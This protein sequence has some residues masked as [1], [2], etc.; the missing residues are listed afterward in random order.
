MK[1]FTSYG[2]IAFLNG[3]WNN[4][5]QLNEIQLQTEALKK[6]KRHWKEY[7]LVWDLWNLNASLRHK[8]KFSDLVKK[9]DDLFPPV[10]DLN[11][12]YKNLSCSKKVMQ[13]T[14]FRIPSSTKYVHLTFSFLSSIEGCAVTPRYWTYFLSKALSPRSK[15]VCVLHID[16]L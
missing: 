5:T 13:C 7:R 3:P 6:Q 8:N 15:S 16:D 4:L 12:A 1:Y 9:V 14:A 10:L 11:K 2:T